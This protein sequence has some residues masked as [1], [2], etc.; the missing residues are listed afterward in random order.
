MCQ[1]S[2]GSCFPGS[3]GRSR[4]VLVAEL[5]NSTLKQPCIVPGSYLS[6]WPVKGLHY[7]AEHVNLLGNAGF[8]TQVCILAGVSNI[9]AYQGTWLSTGN[10]YV[11]VSCWTKASAGDE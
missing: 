2:S 11:M 5:G 3:V 1:N 10:S 9:S 6:P 7:P 8:G 4:D